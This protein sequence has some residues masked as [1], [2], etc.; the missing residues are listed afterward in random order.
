[1]KY[2]DIVEI[3]ESFQYSI[4]LQFDINDINKIKEYIPTS[5]SCEVLE[6]YIDSLLGNASKATTLVG[7]YG[8][9][10]S[11]LLLVLITL[12]NNYHIKDEEII[13]ALLE[14]IKKINESLY[15]KLLQIRQ[16][17]L[18][19]MPIIINSN[20]NDMNQAF[21]LAVIEALEKEKISDIVID[22]YFDKAI[23]IIEKWEKEGHQDIIERLEK[24]LEEE[25]INLTK[26]KDKLKIFDEVA[27]K[28]FK[29][30]YSQAMHGIEFNPLINTDIIK[31]YK[32]INYKIAE[33]GYNGML[34]I[35]DE[36]SKFLEYV[37][38]ESMMRDLKIIQD[39]AELAARTGKREQII[40]SCITHKTI[41]E[42][43][44]NLKENKVNAFKTVEGRFREIQF[45]RSM[46]Q[47]YEIVAQTIIKKAKFG[48]YIKDKMQNKKTFYKQVQETFAFTN[49][50][51]S[52]ELI[53]Q[54]CYPLNPVTVYSLIHLSEKIA[55]NE[56]TLFT[57]LTDDDIDGFKNFI[58]KEDDDSLFNIDKIYNYFHSILKKESDE[59]IKEIWVK[60]ENSLNRTNDEK[61]IKVLKALAVIFMINNFEELVPRDNSLKL[62]LD[63]EETEFNKTIQNLIEKGIIKRKKTDQT[64]DFCTVYNREVLKEIERVASAKFS[65]INEKQTLSK[66][67]DLGYIIPR[68]YNQELKMI[69]FFKMLLI[70]EEELSNLNSFKILEKEN[71]SDGLVLNLIKKSKNVDKLKDKIKQIND[72]KVILRIPE[73]TFSEELFQALR[74]YEA[75]QYIKNVEDNEDEIIRELELIQ[76]EEIELV[77][78]EIEKKL[79][80]L[81]IKEICYLNQTLKHE[82]LTSFI[83]DICEKIYNKTPV[84]NNEMIN[85]N[86]ISS[87]MS[88]VRQ[89]VI[90]SVLNRNKSLIKNNTSAEATVYKA[91]VEKKEQKDIRQVLNVIKEFIKQ[92]EDK[93][94]ISIEELCREMQEEPY[95]IRKGIL[96]ILIAIA[97]EE[98]G[99][100]IVLYYQNRE[101]E[102]NRRKYFKNDSRTREI[103]YL[104]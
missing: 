6:Y 67:I 10:K 62:A 92:A 82:K 25:G 100:N 102:V 104:C 48:K 33:H 89:I 31:Y 83:S 51:K 90:D 34:I 43:I 2:S 19:Y 22:T 56:R 97:I 77:Q 24:D 7:P 94:K 73:E 46:E 39:F 11:H 59:S 68:R 30:V 60:T 20:Y 95:G 1:M 79:D 86:E 9:G 55:Q 71:F 47:N 58:S 75:I 42:Y 57:F 98:Y 32:D 40:F 49:I 50:P 27:Y 78:N 101:I 91:I 17:K 76:E 18:K 37:G 74:E 69:R 66:M 5:D 26:L 16:A 99:E 65:E 13:Q 8:K 87:P 88:K 61:E 15:T 64:Y 81:H 93:E 36:F 52:E 23:N 29:K 45:N 96:P 4:N 14:K 80:P 53:Y 35:F 70:S 54:G 12:L 3:N 28:L 85:K 103:L 63:M 72:P 41:N 84:I 44:K 21:L 38:N